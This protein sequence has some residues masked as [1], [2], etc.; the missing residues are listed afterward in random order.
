MTDLGARQR[1]EARTDACVDA[2]PRQP[3]E[4]VCPCDVIPDLVH[5]CRNPTYLTKYLFTYERQCSLEV[6]LRL[7]ASIVAA[8]S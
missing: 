5:L 7:P 1:L 6:I 8:A 4:H 2:T 3:D